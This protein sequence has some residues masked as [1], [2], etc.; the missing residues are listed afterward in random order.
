[1]TL[2]LSADQGTARQAK[3]RY[4]HRFEFTP[5][6][7]DEAQRLSLY[8]VDWDAQGRRK[9]VVVGSDGG[10]LDRRS[11]A[12]FG[13]GRW[14]SWEVRGRVR[15]TLTALAGPDAVLFG[16]FLDPVVAESRR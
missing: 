9:E 13:D 3:A 5:D 7:G 14:L 1:L 8:L 12:G 15:F 16:V 11:V 6:T 4:D 2:L 10:E